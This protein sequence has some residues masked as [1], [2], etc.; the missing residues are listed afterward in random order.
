M[1]ENFE[2]TLATGENYFS[3]ILGLLVNNRD[4]VCFPKERFNFGKTGKIYFLRPWS[5]NSQN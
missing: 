1:P 2:Q 5:Q 4:I 3:L